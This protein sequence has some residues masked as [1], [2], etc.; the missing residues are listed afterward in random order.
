MDKGSHLGVVDSILA[1]QLAYRTSEAAFDSDFEAW[2]RTP[3]AKAEWSL[4]RRINETAEESVEIDGQPQS[5]VRYFAAD[6]VPWGVHLI[7]VRGT[8]VGR[9]VVADLDIFAEGALLDAVFALLPGG[10]FVE[11]DWKAWMAARVAR[12]TSPLRAIGVDDNIVGL[13]RFVDD[14]AKEDAATSRS[15]D[16]VIVG[17]SLGGAVALL[18]AARQDVRAI[19]VSP[20]G[21]GMT[22]G[23][24]GVSLEALQRH[25][26]AVHSTHDWV[27]LIDERVVPSQGWP[28]DL[29]EWGTH[30]CHML[31][32]P[33]ELFSNTCGDVYGRTMLA[34][35]G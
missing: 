12:I 21:L 13:E 7:G 11:S 32:A 14:L 8:T 16:T 19:G 3:Q 27:S 17:H 34:T 25:G 22:R 24:F 29:Q 15:M 26:Y 20:P 23:K 35:T 9:D 10:S 18:V 4:R 5:V 31:D 2:F 33:W 30:G 28:C 1:S 6:S